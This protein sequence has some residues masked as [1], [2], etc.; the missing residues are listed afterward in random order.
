MADQATTPMVASVATLRT[1]AKTVSIGTLVLSVMLAS[2]LAWNLHYISVSYTGH[3]IT[4]DWSGTRP[5]PVPPG[6]VPPG[7]TPEPIPQPTEKPRVLFFYDAQANRTR[8]QDIVL[9]STV[10][11]KYLNTHCLTDTDG[12]PAYRFWDKT[13][14]TLADET[15]G[16]Q[17]A[18][19]AAIA[20]PS[21]T[22]KM[23]IFSGAVTKVYP[24][25]TEAEA[26]NTLRQWGG[27]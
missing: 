8:D 6:P 13:T 12:L 16:W 4:V 10:I 18:L 24:V 17:S 9:G 1:P 27:N 14:P 22:P 21:P 15:I 5:T 20:D 7:P 26:I 25:T 23:L 2:F 19:K 11:R 3:S